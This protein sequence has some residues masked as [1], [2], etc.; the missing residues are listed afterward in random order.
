MNMGILGKSRSRSRGAGRT[1][2]EMSVHALYPG[3]AVADHGKYVSSE[4]GA[5]Q[6]RLTVISL[7]AAGPQP[8]RRRSIS[9]SVTK[10]LTG[11]D[12]SGLSV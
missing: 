2:I 4:A 6:W 5:G 12:L 7:T 1:T 8:S 9:I 3:R 11:S 10:D